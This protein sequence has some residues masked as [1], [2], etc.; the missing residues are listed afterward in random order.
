MSSLLV[1]VAVAAALL[2]AGF[3]VAC[4]RAAR[5]RRLALSTLDGLVALVFLLCGLLL[6][7][8][9]VATQGYRALTREELAATIE[10]RPTEARRFEAVVV[11]PDGTRD[12]FD[13]AGDQVYVDA[14]IL[15]W[16]PIA[17]LLG[18]HTAYE[19]DRIGGRYDDIASE[20]VGD[21][22]VHSLKHDKPVDMFALARDV[23]ALRP[24]L[25]PLLDAD[26][27]SA[28]FR[29]VRAPS[30]YDV[31]VSTTGLLIRPREPSEGSS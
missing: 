22:T 17:N 6:G 1:V 4:L 7:L 8:I 28:T 27:G 18:L 5:R 23:E 24:V 13:L 30:V 21:R 11:R 26:Y 20:L 16:K 25:R 3:L 19:L 15:K 10:V 14:H 12:T 29:Q 2:S 9:A 31:Y